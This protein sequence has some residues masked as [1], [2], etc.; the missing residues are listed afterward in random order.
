MI[1]CIFICLIYIIP[2]LLHRDNMVSGPTYNLNIHI[3]SAGRDFL[4]NNDENI[5]LVF[6]PR[7]G[8]RYAVVCAVFDPFGDN[9]PVQFTNSYIAYASVQQLAYGDSLVKNISID[10]SPGNLY[11]FL[12]QGFKGS[13]PA[14]SDQV[15]GMINK[16]KTKAYD[17]LSCGFAMD[18]KIN[19][20]S[21]YGIINLSSLPYAHTLYVEPSAK[22]MIFTGKGFFTKMILPPGMLKPDGTNSRIDSMP[23]LVCGP[24]LEIDLNE[25]SNVIFDS[26][27]HVFVNGN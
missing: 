13:L 24:Y 14:F 22:V 27:A 7:T 26:V 8:D 4:L 3:N 21:T 12:N 25:T 15:F 10:V 18:V 19:N 16:R 1:R 9:N 5:I 11:T 20:V 6:S 17:N 2:A 23:L